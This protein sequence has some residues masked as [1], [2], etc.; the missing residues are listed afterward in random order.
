MCIAGGHSGRLT[1]AASRSQRAAQARRWR[2]DGEVRPASRASVV[3]VC[4]CVRLVLHPPSTRRPGSKQQPAAFPSRAPCAWRR[5]ARW[6]ARLSLLLNQRPRYLSYWAAV[7]S[8]EDEGWPDCVET[9][10]LSVICCR[11]RGHIQE[12]WV[13]FTDMST[14]RKV[15][16]K[17]D[18]MKKQKTLHEHQQPPTPPLK[19]KLH[20]PMRLT[21]Q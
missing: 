16:M 11:L 12:R 2:R 15:F 8:A 10:K 5:L 18:M 9:W 13:L 19:Q 7:R 14:V 21:E 17:N 3:C 20:R 4:V 6:K 1:L